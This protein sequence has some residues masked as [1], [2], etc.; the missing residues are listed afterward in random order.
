MVMKCGAINFR[1]IMKLKNILAIL[2]TLFLIVLSFIIIRA[3]TRAGEFSR[4]TPRFDGTC[5]DIAGLA[6]AE[7]ISLSADKTSIYISSVNR[8]AMANDN[9]VRGAI[10]K[11]PISGIE[12]ISARTDLTQNMPTAFAPVG[13][14]LWTSAEGKTTLMAVNSANNKRS[15]EIFGVE[16]NGT[17]THQK[18]VNIEGASR[19]NDVLA[20]GPDKFYVS[21]ESDYKQGSIEEIFAQT[22]DYDKTGAIYYYDGQKS[23]KLASG[24]T[25]ANSLALSPSG[26]KLYATGTISRALFVY[27]RDK[28][29]NTLIKQEEVFLGTGVDNL[30]VEDDGRIWIAAHPKL[31]TLIGHFSD[32]KKTAPSQVIIL[33]PNQN[34]KGGNIDQVYL[35]NG[36]DGFSG[37]SVAVRSNNT[38]IMGSIFEDG[39]RVCE[40]PK[41]WHQSKSHPAT[42]LIDTERDYAIKKKQAE[43]KLKAH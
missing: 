27:G 42:R 6:G 17:L 14:S 31:Y 5:K 28:Q 12:T 29:N 21:N 24:L 25:F 30:F 23:E 19:L 36:D 15:V 26:D 9:L 20:I 40:L 4:L 10:Y 2:G 34:G 18:T 16:T 39:I 13:I 43:E 11:L 33:E 41:V 35:S 22:L 37:A 3:M 38:M 8:R 1:A 32:A 7:D